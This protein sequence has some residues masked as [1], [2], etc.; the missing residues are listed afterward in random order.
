MDEYDAIHES[1]SR[2]VIKGTVVYRDS[3]LIEKMYYENM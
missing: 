3:Y 2:G 1:R